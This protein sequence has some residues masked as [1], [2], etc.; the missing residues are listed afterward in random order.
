[1]DLKHETTA[2]Y[3]RA[4]YTSKNCKHLKTYIFKYVMYYI[5]LYIG[6]VKIY[7]IQKQFPV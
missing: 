5:F 2:K 7:N 1:M 4:P 3:M 6:L